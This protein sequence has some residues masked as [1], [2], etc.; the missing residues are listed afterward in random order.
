MGNFIQ[1]IP[2][3]SP[4]QIEFAPDIVYENDEEY[5]SLVNTQQEA[6]ST[7]RKLQLQ[8][9]II[10]LKTSITE[11]KSFIDQNQPVPVKDEDK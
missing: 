10:A 8:K 6:L 3:A 4:P 9:E 7:L 11:M 2:C 1:S 5:V